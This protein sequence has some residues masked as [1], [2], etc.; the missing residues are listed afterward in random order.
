[1]PVPC[2]H[3][4]LKDTVIGSI[5]FKRIAFGIMLFKYAFHPYVNR[6]SIYV[7]QPE[8]GYAVGHFYAYTEQGG[9]RVFTELLENAGLESPFEEETLKGVC[10]KA[11]AWLDAY[12]LTG[13]K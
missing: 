12:D 7:M 13:L 8:Q 10:E 9:S 2:I 3:I 4:L 11:A 6:K 5:S 1:M